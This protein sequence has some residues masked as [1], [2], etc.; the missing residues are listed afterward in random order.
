MNDFYNYIQQ[1]DFYRKKLQLLNPFDS[2]KEIDSFLINNLE[3]FNKQY[4]DYIYNE[5]NKQKQN[6]NIFEL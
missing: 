4:I 1:L 2:K 6:K 5:Y 3:K